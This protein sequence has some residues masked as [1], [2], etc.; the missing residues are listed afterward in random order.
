[1]DRLIDADTWVLPRQMQPAL[2]IR[3]VPYSFYVWPPMQV[4]EVAVCG[5]RYWPQRVTDEQGGAGF[6]S[7]AGGGG[8]RALAALYRTHALYVQRKSGALSYADD[9]SGVRSLLSTAFHKVSRRLSCPTCST[10]TVKSTGN[11]GL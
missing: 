8:G 10:Q 11:E 9:P 2:K 6:G 4:Q 5:P 3:A 7:G 1:M